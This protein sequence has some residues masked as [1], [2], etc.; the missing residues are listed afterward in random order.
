MQNSNQLCFSYI[1]MYLF[2]IAYSPT[3]SDQPVLPPGVTRTLSFHHFFEIA[4]R[5]YKVILSSWN[6]PFLVLYQRWFHLGKIEKNVEPKVF[7]HFCSYVRLKKNTL[8]ENQFKRLFFLPNSNS[9]WLVW[10]GLIVA[11]HQ[12]PNSSFIF[13]NKPVVDLNALLSLFVPFCNFY[14]SESIV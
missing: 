6:F 7:S 2:K 10:G 11:T 1:E 4:A 14:K 8:F 13:K 12:Y 9:K 5:L 3:M